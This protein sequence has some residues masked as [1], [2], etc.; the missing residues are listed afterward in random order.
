M[1]TVVLTLLLAG[2]FV[3][4]A[5][6]QSQWVVCGGEAFATCATGFGPVPYLAP[7]AGPF[8]VWVWA[9]DYFG[10]SESSGTAFVG[11][12]TDISGPVIERSKG[13]RAAVIT[14]EPRTAVLLTTG[15]LIVGVTFWRGRPGGG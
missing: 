15:L 2:I 5:S 7:N 10:L 4:P 8:R 6:A 12:V 11:N 1:R 14:P 13:A 3:A 9:W